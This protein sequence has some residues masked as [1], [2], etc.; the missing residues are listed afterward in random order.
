MKMLFPYLGLLVS[1]PYIHKKETPL[2]SQGSF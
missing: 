1:Q 2:I